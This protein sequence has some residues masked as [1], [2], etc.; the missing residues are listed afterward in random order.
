MVVMR[1]IGNPNVLQAFICP[2]SLLSFE[3]LESKKL[4]DNFMWALEKFLGKAL[5]KPI[6]MRRTRWLT[7]R[8]FLG[9]SSFYSIESERQD[10][11]PNDLAEPLRD[12][13]GKPI[14]LFA[15]EATHE[16][17]S[18]NSHGAVESGWRAAQEI[19]D[20]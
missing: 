9:T 4:V 16:K 6:D 10:V 18:G 1:V 3:K 17:F 2:K 20:Y 15:G 7:S 19:L 12:A 5:P 8:N 14:V 11:T 13:E